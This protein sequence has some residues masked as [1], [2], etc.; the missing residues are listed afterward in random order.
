[1]SSAARQIVRT[2][3]AADSS[4]PADAERAPEIRDR[5]TVGRA[6]DRF[7]HAEHSVGP[8]G[9]LAVPVTGF[10][11]GSSGA[12]NFFEELLLGRMAAMKRRLSRCLPSTI[13]SLS[14]EFAEIVRKWTV[15]RKSSAGLA[16]GKGRVH[17]TGGVGYSAAAAA[18]SISAMRSEFGTG[19]P[20]TGVVATS[21]GV[22]PSA[23]L[24][25][26]S[27]PRSSR[28]ATTS[29]QPRPAA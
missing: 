17:R 6:F 27:A 20:W 12:E 23:S 13:V 10:R 26:G 15:D 22:R 29:A 14:D 21:S 11:H 7:E 19:R 4:L 18:F 1:M 25:V 3:L 28:C 2:L 24:I 8:E 5:E 16:V 9:G